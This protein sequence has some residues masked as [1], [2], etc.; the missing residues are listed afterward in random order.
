MGTWTGQEKLSGEAIF[1]LRPRDR[2]QAV[3]EWG[4]ITFQAEDMVCAHVPQ[5]KAA[6]RG[7]WRISAK[8]THQAMAEEY[9]LT[10]FNVMGPIPRP[11]FPLKYFHFCIILNFAL[12]N[13]E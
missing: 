3:T 8:L 12:I 13:Q 4:Y 11:K 6:R 5:Q 2:R 9:Y 1:T 10:V 7:H